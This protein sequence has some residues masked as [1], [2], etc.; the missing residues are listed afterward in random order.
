MKNELSSLWQEYKDPKYNEL[1]EWQKI[2]ENSV[3]FHQE[4]DGPIVY[5]M[6]RKYNIPFDSPYVNN[7]LSLLL[8]FIIAY[9]QDVSNGRRRPLQ[10]ICKTWKCIS[11]SGLCKGKCKKI[12]VFNFIFPL[13]GGL[14]S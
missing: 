11:T 7:L 13:N 2:T 8:D 4:V 1:G 9:E 3:S 12:F 5:W 6:E 10:E 14:D